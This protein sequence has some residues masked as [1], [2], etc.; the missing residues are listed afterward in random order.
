MAD[1]AADRVLVVERGDSR[2]GLGQLARVA[3]REGIPIVPI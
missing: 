3:V 2:E 1:E